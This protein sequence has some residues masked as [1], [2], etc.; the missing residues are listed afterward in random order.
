MPSNIEDLKMNKELAFSVM[1]ANVKKKK[2]K[3][4]QI[5]INFF[6]FFFLLVNK[7]SALIK[8]YLWVL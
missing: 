6:F 7:K 4:K 2:L 5:L 3:K 8:R 1:M